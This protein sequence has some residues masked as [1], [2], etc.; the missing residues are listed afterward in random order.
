MEI[1]GFNITPQSGSAGADIPISISIAAINEGLDKSIEIEGVCGDKQAPLA[2]VH[3]GMR[4]KYIT[5]DGE[6]F[7]TLDEEIYGCL[8]Q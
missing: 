2:L 6:V 1:N 7:M 3:E 5:T 4:E 8:K